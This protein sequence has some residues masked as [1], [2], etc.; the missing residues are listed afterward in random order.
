M[1]SPRRRGKALES[2]QNMNPVKARKETLQELG[3]V[4]QRIPHAY[5]QTDFSPVAQVIRMIEAGDVAGSMSD[6]EHHCD[7]MDQCMKKVG[8]AYEAGFA[9]SLTSYDVIFDHVPPS[10][11]A[12]SSIGQSV[13][14]AAEAIRP[15]SDEL[16][17]LIVSLQTTKHVI[18]IL[19]KIE[20]LAQAPEEVAHNV[21]HKQWVNAAK[22]VLAGTE[23]LLGDDLLGIR[24]LEILRKRMLDL[25]N[26]LPDMILSEVKSYVYLY[27]VHVPKEDMARRVTALREGSLKCA[28]ELALAAGDTS[29]VVADASNSAAS[30]TT[31]DESPKSGHK[32]SAAAL[33]ANKKRSSGV[34]SHRRGKSISSSPTLGRGSGAGPGSAVVGS[35]VASSAGVGSAAMVAG[36]VASAGGS[37][38]GPASLAAVNNLVVLDEKVDC[39]HEIARYI[40]SLVAALHCM[41]KAASSLNE[42]AGGTDAAHKRL[43][44]SEFALFLA[45]FERSSSTVAVR[46]REC[47]DRPDLVERSAAVLKQVVESS[48]NKLALVLHHHLLVAASAR[49]LAR[50]KPAQLSNKYSPE[51]Q[52]RSIQQA[53]LDML[54]HFLFD[55]KSSHISEEAAVATPLA[56]LNQSMLFRFSESSA[57]FTASESESKT[58]GSSINTLQQPQSQQ[59]KL[60]LSLTDLSFIVSP[61]QHAPHVARSTLLQPSPFSS[62]VLFPL[63]RAFDH[64]C[65]SLLVMSALSDGAESENVLSVW[66][67]NFVTS[68]YVPR[69]RMETLRVLQKSADMPFEKAAGGSN[70]RGKIGNFA[71]LLVLKKKKKKK[72]K[73]VLSSAL[74]VFR[75]LSDLQADAEESPDQR[76]AFVVLANDIVQAFVEQM[77]HRLMQLTLHTETFRRL[78]G[79]PVL[80]LMRKDDGNS[81]GRDFRGV[82]RRYLV[83]EKRVEAGDLIRN[84]TDLSAVALLAS[85]LDWL[86]K[87]ISSK[88]LLD[89]DKKM[90]DRCSSA[91]LSCRA[92]IKLDLRHQCYHHLFQINVLSYCGVPLTS[93]PDPCVR[94]LSVALGQV[95]DIVDTFVTEVANNIF[96]SPLIFVENEKKK[97]KKIGSG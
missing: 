56:S 59:K 4:L 10:V 21:E 49:S 64:K 70:V 92:S 32:L 54:E 20:E 86:Q 2:S 73:K 50:S 12:V 1:K 30:S 14:G 91:L 57:A 34:H 97:K 25:R 5:Q 55:V 37:A 44:D 93:D 53:L 41:D 85:S 38:V 27:T 31:D 13:R 62:S 68:V 95:Q 76:A 9:S 7:E 77:E 80:E 58:P 89:E 75:V 28:Q 11:E 69:I 26:L 23:H 39:R 24:G 36:S 71:F 17:A 3:E 29:V 96:I 51:K 65:R 66:M 19:R 40:H 47:I 90:V 87:E 6:L 74:L 8:A 81:F 78:K 18:E 61:G 45:D 60:D 43:V 82:E 46:H 48:C 67:D 72:K 33:V 79:T 88:I 35:T 83:G 42:L 15:R 22:I 63:L 16:N 52:W 84:H 94:N